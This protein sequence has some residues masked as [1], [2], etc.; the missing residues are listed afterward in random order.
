MLGI[1]NR[2]NDTHC[3]NHIDGSKVVR[4]VRGAKGLMPPNVQKKAK[5][6]AYVWRG[7]VRGSNATLGRL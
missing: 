4:E 7:D 1:S 5:V 2:L 6:G 3:L